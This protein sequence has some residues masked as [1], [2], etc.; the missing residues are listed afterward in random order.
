[1]FKKLKPIIFIIII[2]TIVAFAIY[3]KTNKK[4]MNIKI[5]EET[6]IEE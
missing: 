3:L 2:L 1:M 6:D 4:E 5:A